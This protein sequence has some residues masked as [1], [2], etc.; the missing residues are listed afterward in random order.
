MRRV[1]RMRLECMWC[2]SM[3]C[4][5]PTFFCDL[6]R[7][8]GG[9]KCQSAHVTAAGGLGARKHQGCLEVDVSTQQQLQ[10]ALP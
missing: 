4:F 2:A 10:S 7:Q 9:E 1:E 6:G 8:Q 5:P 3:A